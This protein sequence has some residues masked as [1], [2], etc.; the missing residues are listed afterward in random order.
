MARIRTIKPEFWTDGAI[1]QMSPWARLLFIG[2]W[3]FTLCDHGHV[4]DD[5]LRLKMQVFPNDVVDIES[6][7]EELL[8]SGRLARIADSEGRSYLHIR[9][10]EDHQKIDPRWKTRCPACNS[11]EL[12]ETRVSLGEPHRV[13]V[14]AHRDSPKLP[15]TP[16]RKG[17]DGKGWEN[18]RPPTVPE[19]GPVKA[20]KATPA[21]PEEFATFWQAYPRREAKGA[22]RAAYVKALK[23][24]SSDVIV[25]AATAYAKSKAGEDRKYIALPATWLNAERWDDEPATTSSAAP[26]SSWDRAPKIGE[27]WNE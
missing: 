26:R 13:I 5:P 15:E 22:A 3:N 2:S 27:G 20:I 19:S 14:E 4:D 9:R 11:P 25:K 16:P 24:T 21:E 7:L 17:R 10:F 1:V 23:K 6:L 8:S 12:T 18:T